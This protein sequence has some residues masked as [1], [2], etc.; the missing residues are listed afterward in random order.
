MRPSEQPPFGAD[1]ESKRWREGIHALCVS[2]LQVS[3]SVDSTSILRGEVT[4]ETEGRR[5]PAREL[6]VGGTKPTANGTTMSAS[7][8][9]Y[10]STD[11][12][13]HAPVSRPPLLRTRRRRN[14][15]AQGARAD[16]T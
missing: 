5:C 12:A 11:Y 2:L 15:G 1:D 10:F 16:L 3:L 13:R 7:L 9:G 14:A 4:F 8:V 6:V